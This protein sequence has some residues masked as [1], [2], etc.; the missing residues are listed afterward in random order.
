LN[1]EEIFE[2][3]KILKALKAILLEP[4]RKEASAE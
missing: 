2:V 3:V 4:E 1:N